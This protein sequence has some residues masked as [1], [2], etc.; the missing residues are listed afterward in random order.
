VL[1]F[2]HVGITL[3]IVKTYENIADNEGELNIDYRYVLFGAMLPDIID[4]PLKVML[5]DGPIRSARYI[6]HSVT[7]MLLLLL[8]SVIFILA[9][10]SSKFLILTLCSYIHLVLDRMWLY[11][12]VFLWPFYQL[13]LRNESVS[14]ISNGIMDK[15][16]NAYISVS[17]IDWVKVYSKPEV[18]IPEAIGLLF[19]VCF[20]LRLVYQGKV[21]S[22][23]ETGKI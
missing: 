17:Q 21:R 13:R 5:S 6:G 11:P 2:G 12:K 20:L 14:T 7:F 1:F 22:F 15:L 19:I 18:F 10:K 4:K 9:F 23:I 16:E 8:I 3:A